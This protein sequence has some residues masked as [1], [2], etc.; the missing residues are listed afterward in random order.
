MARPRRERQRC[1]TCRQWLSAAEFSDPWDKRCSA[2]R[3]AISA[4]QSAKVAQVP[5]LAG[6]EWRAVVGWEGLYEVSS[7][8]RVRSLTRI[9][10]SVSGGRAVYGH[11]VK[12]RAINS[13][14]L[15]AV[16]NRNDRTFPRLIHRLVAEAFI[17]PCPLEHEVNHKDL[18]KHN[19][20]ETNLEWVTRSENHLHR[21]RAGI[22]RGERNGTARLT[23]PDVRSIRARYRPGGGPGYKALAKE[24]GIAWETVRGVIKRHVWAWLEG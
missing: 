6:E 1:Y 5:A 14:Y 18:N 12:P 3:Q 21:A 24:Y 22:G 10:T 7:E 11:L 20:C 19:N 4:V 2:C 15:V 17:G 23:E 9:V 16:L 13:G 8:G